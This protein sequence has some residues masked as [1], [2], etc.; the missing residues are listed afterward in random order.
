MYFDHEIEAGATQAYHEDP[1]TASEDESYDLQAIDVLHGKK[2][3]KLRKAPV[4]DDDAEYE[5]G[6]K[7]KDKRKAEPGGFLAFFGLGKKPTAD[8][9]ANGNS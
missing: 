5:G 6:A 1:W 2:P 8:T 4:V 9:L 7:A 3:K